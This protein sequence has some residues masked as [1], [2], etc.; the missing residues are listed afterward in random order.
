MAKILIWDLET[1]DLR[2]DW[3]FTIC[4][5]YKWL[6]EDKVYC[7]SIMD[8][9]GWKDDLINDRKLI[10]ELHRVITQ[11][12]MVVTFY[13]KGF[14]LKWMNSK[15]LEY[16]LSV[17]PNS[18]HV[19][20]FFVAKTNLNLSRKSL[21]NIGRY[22]K[23]PNKKYR[24]SGDI[25]KQA[26]IGNESAIQKVIEHCKADVL[27]TEKLYYRLRP[28]IRTHPRVAGWE[29]CRN[30]GSDRLQ[31]RGTAITSTKGKRIRVMCTKCGAWETRA[32]EHAEVA[33]G[34]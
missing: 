2:A 7:P 33:G 34:Q 4:G 16:G 31:K 1:S 19:D 15:C 25:W 29:P 22:L 28:L 30:C 26:R 17:L 21:E 10:K 3:G 18:P 14:D 12:D 24:V 8:Y 23:L 9:E 32:P 13:G 11:A 27:M 20:L 6:G 5:G